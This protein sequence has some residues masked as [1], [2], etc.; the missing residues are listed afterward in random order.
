DMLPVPVSN[1][2]VGFGLGNKGFAGGGSISFHQFYE[3][4][5]ASPPGSQ[6]SELIVHDDLQ[7]KLGIFTNAISFG[8]YALF[9]AGFGQEFEVWA[10]DPNT[11]NPW[12]PLTKLSTG[13]E[14]PTGVRTGFA[15]GDLGFVILR[16]NQNNLWM[17]VPGLD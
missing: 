13:E 1:T 16:R 14:E 9:I 5:P 2:R 15:I 3:F 12:S 7:G 4:D 17:Y 11:E 8:T 10:F 6:W